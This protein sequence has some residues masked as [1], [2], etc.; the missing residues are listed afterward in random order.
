MQGIEKQLLVRT[1]STDRLF[2]R[3]LRGKR[4]DNKMDHLVCFLPGMLA[5]GAVRLEEG[6]AAARHMAQAKD[7]TDTCHFMYATP[8]GSCASCRMT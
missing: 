6:E 8:T 7:L 2:A 1:K 4:P 5:L 3:E